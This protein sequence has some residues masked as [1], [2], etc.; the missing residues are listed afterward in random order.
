MEA[1][2]EDDKPIPG[3]RPLKDIP[4]SSTHKKKTVFKSR[5]YTLNVSYILLEMHSV[6][7]RVI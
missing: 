5:S 1:I 3:I 6:F 4:T 2:I 7:K